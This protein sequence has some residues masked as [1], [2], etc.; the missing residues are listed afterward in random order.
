[1]KLEI[2]VP[3]SALKSEEDLDKFL[4]ILNKYE[5]HIDCVYF[6]L[7]YI[8]QTESM[9]GIRL[10]QA[11]GKYDLGRAETFLKIILTQCKNRFKTKIL[12]NDLYPRIA[13]E[14]WPTVEKKINYYNAI[15]EV[16]SLVVADFSVIDV[17]VQH[18]SQ[19]NF[20]LSTNATT[21]LES[22]SSALL[23]DTNDKINSIVIDR[24]SNRSPYKLETFRKSHRKVLKNKELILMANEGCTLYCPY[25]QSGDIEIQLENDIGSMP[26]NVHGKGCAQ[27][28]SKDPWLF[29]TSP[30]LTREMLTYPEYENYNIK[31]AGRNLP[32]KAIKRIIEY[33]LGEDN[34]LTLADLSNIHQCPEISLSDLG[35]EYSDLVL[36]C[37]KGCA[38][39]L[40]C[41]RTYNKILDSKTGKSPIDSR[42]DL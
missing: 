42:I 27:I 5:E 23:Y 8:T 9:F 2:P 34:C 14:K 13:L 32:P 10:A 29:L 22:L 37:S 18:G 36:D 30:F 39:C 11:D 4:S 35:Q 28:V 41:R 12:L 31:I 19:Y 6:P 7:G 38:S 3:Y 1:M 20:C 26:T 33:Y 24:N 40:L 16:S 15:A 25:K 17:A 21:S